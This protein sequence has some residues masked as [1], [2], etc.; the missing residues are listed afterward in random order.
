MDIV[1]TYTQIYLAILMVSF[2]T[3][4]DVYWNSLLAYLALETHIFF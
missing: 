2:M 1:Q 3:L 4:F